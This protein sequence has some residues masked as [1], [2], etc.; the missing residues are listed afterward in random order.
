MTVV[1]ILT[2]RET[3]LSTHGVQFCSVHS[4]E[5]MRSMRNL[6]YR[7]V[8]SQYA[9]ALHFAKGK[10]P[11]CACSNERAARKGRRRVFRRLIMHPSSRFVGYVNNHLPSVH[12]SLKFIPWAIRIH[13]HAHRTIVRLELLIPWRTYYGHKPALKALHCHSLDLRA[14]SNAWNSK[15]RFW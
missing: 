8:A 11:F 5:C 7:N 2:A 14:V 1:Y 6:V 3:S 9:S 15:I 13:S 10:S 12:P 4:R